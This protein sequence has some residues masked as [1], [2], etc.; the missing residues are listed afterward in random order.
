[1]FELEPEGWRLRREDMA[2]GCT[3]CCPGGAVS[4][5]H[6]PLWLS[7]SSRARGPRGLPRPSLSVLPGAL[8]S[9]VCIHGVPT[10]GLTSVLT[11]VYF[12][13]AFPARLI[14]AQR[15]VFAGSEMPVSLPL[16][17]HK[18]GWSCHRWGTWLLPAEQLRL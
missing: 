13:W 11:C 15:V 5:L 6:P 7:V 3:R 8:G 4:G 10:P 16:S 2:R 9:G 17:I 12:F 14:C 18:M 1:M